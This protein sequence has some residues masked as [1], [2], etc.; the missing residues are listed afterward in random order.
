MLIITRRVGE[1]LII[2]ALGSVTMT[3][4][5]ASRVQLEIAAPG[6]PVRRY[7]ASAIQSSEATARGTWLQTRVVERCCSTLN[8]STFAWSRIGAAFIG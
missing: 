1:T 4:A 2:E 8:Q 3:A 5:K 6:V 7:K